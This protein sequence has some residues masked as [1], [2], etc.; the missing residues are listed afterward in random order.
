M[1]IDF[2]EVD[3]KQFYLL[4]YTI[5]L[6]TFSLSPLGIHKWMIGSPVIGLCYSL[7]HGV[8]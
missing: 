4:L 7:Q 2:N 5:A 1:F 3:V 6:R 8:T